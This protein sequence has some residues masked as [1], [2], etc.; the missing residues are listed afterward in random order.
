VIIGSPPRFEW[1][2]KPLGG[3]WGLLPLAWVL[4]CAALA[5]EDGPTRD[6]VRQAVPVSVQTATKSSVP[7][8]L[9]VI[10]NV[11]P[12]A[13]VAVKSRVDGQLQR[14]FFEEG[15]FVKKGAPLFQIDS[16]PFRIVLAQA[17]ANLAKDSAQLKNAQLEAKRA[18]ALLTDKLVSQQEHDQKTSLVDTLQAALQ[19]DQAL[20]AGAQGNVDYTAISSPISGRTGGLQVA[21]GNLVKANTDPPLV[22]IRQI[23]PIYVSFAAPADQLPD[24][25]RFSEQGSLAVQIRVPNQEQATASG[26]LTFIDNTVD[27][28]TGT[29]GLKAT[30]ANEDRALW[31]GQFVRVSLLLSSLT[32]AV[33]VPSRAV[34]AG[35]QGDH[36]FVVTKELTAQSRAVTTGVRFG[37]LIVIEQGLAV[38]EQVVT[39][40]QLNLVPG[41]KI[42]IKAALER[43]PQGAGT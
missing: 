4:A 6:P 42:E 29:I 38:G 17:R 22:V 18:E 28:A 14:V 36:V 31:P 8:E 27:T 13:T 43:P 7:L 9:S 20:V 21:A 16:G 19:A 12:I 23:S 35:Q 33:V 26:S 34:Q 25:R 37:E 15:Q 39:D 41:T 32:D 1:A 11:I 5:C 3:E 30:F 40:G 2:R 10:G 24:I